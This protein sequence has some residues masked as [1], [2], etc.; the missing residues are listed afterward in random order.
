LFR[1]AAKTADP[2]ALL[3]SETWK[4]PEARLRL[5]GDE[6]D[7]SM[8]YRF[9]AAVLG[10][11]RG[12]DYTDNDGVIAGLSAG[13]F[14]AALRAVQEDYPPPAF[15]TAMNLISSHDV[16]RAVNVL[17]RDGVDPATQQPVDGFAGGRARLALAAV[18]QF[19]LPGAPTVYYGDEVG[20]AGFGS[21]PQRDDPYNR[22]PYPWEDAAGYAD[23]PEWRQAD[24]ELLAI[25][26]Q[27]GT[28]RQMHSFL[29]TGSWD[30]LPAGEDENLYVFGRKDAS[31]AA[32]IA[33]NRGDAEAVA[34]VDASGYLPF[35]AVLTDVF[36]NTP[37]LSTVSEAGILSFT[38]P[39][40][41]YR[42]LLTGDDVDL[43]PPAPPVVSG[44]ED[45]RELRLAISPGPDSGPAPTE[46]VVL[47]S[48]VAGGY[49]EIGRTPAETEV[50]FADPGVA[51][52]TAYH[53]QVV[54]VAANG[55]RSEP[56]TLEPL[57]PHAPIAAVTVDE[58]LAIQHTLSAVEPSPET[59]GAVM[60]PG[61]TDLEGAGAGLR[62]QAG[63][64]PA[65]TDEWT[66]TDGQYVT[67]NQGGANVYAAR[68]LPE[69]AGEYDIAWRATTTGGREWTLSDGRGRMTVYAAADAEAPKPPFRL[70]PLARSGSQLAF[71]WRV[72]RPADLHNFRI[73]RA[74]ISAGEEG[75]ATRIDMPKESSVY[76]DTNV[77]AGSTYT[78]TVQVV[79]TGFN[80]SAPSQPLT[81]TA[82]LTMVD[83]TWRVLV[84]A[85]TPP[86]DLV[87]IAGDNGGVFGAS[88]NPGLQPMTLV[89]EG[90]WEWSRTVQEGTDLLY[91][92]TRGSWET[93]EQW[94][95][96]SG[97]ANRQ[98][99]VVA[100]PDGTMLVDDTAT[101]WGGEGPDDRRGVQAWRDPLVTAA[102]PAAG[103]S[104]PV[105]SVRVEFA[106]P[107]SAADPNQVIAVTDAAGAPVPGSVAQEGKA[108]VWTPDAP[109]APGEHTATVFNVSTDTPMG[110]AYTWGFTVE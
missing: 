79:D 94:G 24:A 110:K 5:L 9:R 104:G 85:A 64:S 3:I 54:A 81:V 73:C 31:G 105:E 92:Y 48:L 58:P 18:L 87:F 30:T 95:S 65:G 69:A 43:A 40:L 100:G 76:T 63:W 67:D 83:V 1:S 103:G 75:C 47:R 14:D 17:D 107:V 82:E 102:E 86:D 90:V 59:L 8:N 35:G 89:G 13:E 2:D 26:Q 93:V 10:F 39:A 97:M 98:L 61:L 96:I 38:V 78:Y 16:N 91:K 20:L 32:I 109:L 46:F 11:L 62:A 77:T 21:D 42:V 4:E 51:N 49:E 56:V 84:P 23:L 34:T 44:E 50:V 6:F 60:A 71:A 45:D 41:G 15:A 37:A 36:T 7:S 68:L 27:L 66:W 106:T 74:E 25:Y 88:Y 108:F 101:D 52:G 33:V 12:T 28:L 53:Y 72:S 70:D 99:E 22:Q 57:I 19:T 29:R 55:M 80:V